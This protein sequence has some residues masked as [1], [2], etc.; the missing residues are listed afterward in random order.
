MNATL[1]LGVIVLYFLMVFGVS[2][3]TT[4]RRDRDTETSIVAIARAPGGW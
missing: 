3:W 4:R 1:V 2:W